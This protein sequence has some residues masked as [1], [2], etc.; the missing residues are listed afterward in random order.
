MTVIGHLTEL[1][2]RLIIVLL[3]FTAFTVAGFCFAPKILV[4]IKNTSN[5]SNIV[6]NVF[7]FTDGLMIY[8]K[9]ALLVSVLCTLPVLF[10]QTWKFVRPALSEK[11]AKSTFWYVPIS[12]ILFL[13]GASF[14]Y[15]VLFPLLL[16][17]MSTINQSIGAV[18][19]YGIDRY[20]TFMFNVVFPVSLL[21]EL[22]LAILFLTRV[23]ILNP[24]MLRKSRKAAYFVLVFIALL[25][26]PPDFVSDILVSVPLILLFETGILISAW[27]KRK[28][29]KEGV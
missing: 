8:L 16:Q 13:L 2:K 22:P 25:I 14:S 1:R 11:E 6:W 26:T 7:G 3:S 28:E 9:C 21:F 18:E 27:A 4:W 29:N 10:Y 5:T 24:H 15:F 20:L 17:F 12:F 19:T 23:G